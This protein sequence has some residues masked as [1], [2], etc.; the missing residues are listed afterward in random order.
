M[1]IK[2]R[3]QAKKAGCEFIVPSNPAVTCILK[4]LRPEA[5]RPYLSEG[6]PFSK[7]LLLTFHFTLSAS[8][9]ITLGKKHFFM[10]DCLDMDK[11]WGGW[12]DINRE[13]ALVYGRSDRRICGHGMTCHGK[14]N[15]HA[16]FAVAGGDR[17]WKP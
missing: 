1:K 12:I 9:E 7:N 14:N 16:A 11:K 17:A 5:L 15:K 6:L 3:F 13:N 4:G 2:T 8:F 10:K